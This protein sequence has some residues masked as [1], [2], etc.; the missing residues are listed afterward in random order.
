MVNLLFLIS[1]STNGH[2]SWGLFLYHLTHKCAA[3]AAS[4]W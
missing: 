4:L 3:L 2:D 1:Y